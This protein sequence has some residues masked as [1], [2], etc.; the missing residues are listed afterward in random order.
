VK[1]GFTLIAPR[2]KKAPGLTNYPDSDQ[3]VEAIAKRMWGKIDG[4][5]ITE[6]SYGKGRVILKDI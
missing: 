4:T 2:P 5:A 3:Q 6:N 1:A